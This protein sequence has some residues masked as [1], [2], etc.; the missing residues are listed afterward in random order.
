MVQTAVSVVEVC[1]FGIGLYIFK[2]LFYSRRH[3]PLPPGPAGWPV[4]GNLF[5]V[6]F[7]KTWEA[8]AALG[9]TYGHISSLSSLGRRFV[10]LNSSEAISGVLEKQSSKCSSRPHSTMASELVGFNNGMLFMDDSDRFRQYRK[11]FNRSFGNRNSTAAFNPA[12][13]EETRKFLCSVLQKPE[14]LVDHICKCSPAG[15]IVLKTIYGYTVQQGRDPFIELAR[16]VIT[17]FSLV[18]APGAFLFNVIPAIRYIPKWFPGMRFLKDAKKHNQFLADSILK[19]HQYVL[20]QMAAGTAIPSF[21]STLLDEGVSREEEEAIMCTSMSVFIGTSDTLVSAIHA[22][23]LAMVLFP[24]VQ[25]KARAELDE[26]VGSG[27]L[28]SISDRDFLPYVKAVCQEV[29]RWHS[30]TPIAIPHVATEDIYY[31]GFLIPK[32]SWIIGN[33]W[34]VLH[35]ESIYPDPSVFRPERFL[36]ETPQPQPQKV[37][38]GFGRR[39]CPGSHLAEE[40]LF[41]TVA[42]SLAV[43]AISKEVVDGV[44]VTPKVD[45]TSG[46]V[47]HP[48]PFRYQITARS[49]AAEALLRGSS[50]FALT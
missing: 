45:V 36:G 20:D 39:T 23:F 31:D 32:G 37:C 35:D 1:L 25:T 33:A 3:S 7:E 15:A 29:L 21:S 27:R 12:E 26:V 6:P 38:F 34:A 47:S 13:E 10:V 5:Q 30:I 49:P 8:L 19:P 18:E 4:I 17:I 2:R 16:K 46:V 50:S 44:Q 48:K 11:L 24:E 28:P 14:N 43:L 42:M 40:S 41:I 22:F 9:K